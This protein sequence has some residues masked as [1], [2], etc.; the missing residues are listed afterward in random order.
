MMK[1]CALPMISISME[2]FVVFGSVIGILVLIFDILL[3]GD[4]PRGT[5]GRY[6]VLCV[7]F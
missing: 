3:P 1:L 6:F 4:E 7:E 2:S 5:P